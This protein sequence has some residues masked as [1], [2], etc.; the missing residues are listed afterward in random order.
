MID[1]GFNASTPAATQ[2]PGTMK[3]SLF[4]LFAFATRPLPRRR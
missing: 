1:A 2:F 4:L 3:L